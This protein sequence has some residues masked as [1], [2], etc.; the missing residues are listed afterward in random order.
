MRHVALGH[1]HYFTWHL[2]AIVLSAVVLVLGGAL[3]ISM[4]RNA[5]SAASREGQWRV[6]G[7]CALVVSLMSG[8]AWPY[9]RVVATVNVDSQGN[10]NLR[11]Y[12]GIPLAR[13]PASEVRTVRAADLGGAGQGVGFIEIERSDGTV[14]RTVRVTRDVLERATATLGYPRER[15]VSSYGDR[16]IAAHR[17]SAAG[18]AW[19]AR[20]TP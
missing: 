12:L 16:V 1:W 4:K 20:A 15:I 5:A 11:N 3:L 6:V 8:V 9:L 14:V 17:F 7:W 13:I 10:W 19:V 2:P 18:P